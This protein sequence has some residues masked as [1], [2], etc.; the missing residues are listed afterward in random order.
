MPPAKFQKMDSIDS[1]KKRYEELEERRVQRKLERQQ[2]EQHLPPPKIAATPPFVQSTG[3][4][5]APQPGSSL[6]HAFPASWS[7]DGV[8]DPCAGSED[9]PEI[10]AQQSQGYEPITYGLETLISNSE[11]GNN[12]NSMGQALYPQLETKDTEFGPFHNSQVDLDPPFTHIT[13]RA[14]VSQES[15]P[16]VPQLTAASRLSRMDDGNTS[17]ISTD[18]EDEQGTGDYTDSNTDIPVFNQENTGKDDVNSQVQS[19]LTK[20]DS[21]ASTA[22]TTTFVEEPTA[23]ISAD[24]SQAGN[25]G[26]SSSASGQKGTPAS[27]SQTTAGREKRCHDEVEG[28]N[29]IDGPRPAKRS[30]QEDAAAKT[31]RPLP[32]RG[33]SVHRIGHSLG[34]PPMEPIQ[35]SKFHRVAPRSSTSFRS[36]RSQSGH[37]SHEG[38]RLG[39]NSVQRLK[40]PSSSQSRSSIP[41]EGTAVPN[42]IYGGLNFPNAENFSAGSNRQPLLRMSTYSAEKS[43]PICHVCGFSPERLLQLTDSVE[44]LLASRTSLSDGETSR[45][46]LQLLIGSVRDFVNLSHQER[47]IIQSSDSLKLEHAYTMD[48]TVQLGEEMEVSSDDESTEGTDDS[49]SQSDGAAADGTS[50]SIL[51]KDQRYKRRRWSELEERRLRA[52]VREGKDWNWIADKLQRSE[53][54]VSQHWIIMAQKHGG[55]KKTT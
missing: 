37:Q 20:T 3:T 11:F 21:R 44:M 5:A 32:C 19:I 29:G 24:T 13:P 41:L 30:W 17:C 54:A 6:P 31:L 7:N 12:T 9:L 46:M 45:V 18:L 47:T 10:V 33:P 51:D 39:R 15:Q 49:N 36:F 53:A 48:A 14:D 28:V 27:T 43:A 23:L 52:W 4:S 2:R 55:G 40:Q 25:L 50:S 1:I 38:H 8:D 22:P 42:S 26:R 35:A 16:P 34:S